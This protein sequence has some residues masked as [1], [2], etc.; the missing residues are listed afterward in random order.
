M[1]AMSLV[2]E[3]QRDAYGSEVPV[4]QLLRKALFVARKLQVQ[5]LVQ[6]IDR[7]LKGYHNERTVPEYRE[8]HG[9]VRAKNTV[10]GTIPVRFAQQF[11]EDLLCK[12]GLFVPIGEI[13]SMVARGKQDPQARYVTEFTADQMLFLQQ[14][15]DFDLP[16]PGPLMFAA[17]MSQL[18]R[19]LDAVRNTVLEWSLKL[20]EDG[21]IGE[22]MSFTLEEKQAASTHN[23]Q[24]CII[25]AVQP[26]S[27]NSATVN[28]NVGSDAIEIQA[29][30]QA[31]T[32]LNQLP[33]SERQEALELLDVVEG[34]IIQNKWT[35]TTKACA[36]ELLTF[37]QAV[38]AG[39]ATEYLKNRLGM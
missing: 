30:Q 39:V 5:E 16:T 6:W 21:I 3:L 14:H 2:Q 13:E 27:N 33:D 10:Y 34:D 35:T 29:L 17:S 4:S 15:Y 1:A 32:Q 7:E 23:Y 8:L 20:E 25:G 9:E 26:G 28:Q 24:N 12:H 11:M 19:V 22:G 36:K 38:G 18:E 31:R 37:L